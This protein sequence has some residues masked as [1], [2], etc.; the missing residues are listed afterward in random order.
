M[1]RGP[2]WILLWRSRDTTLDAYVDVHKLASGP[3]CMQA[4]PL[5]GRHLY[6]PSEA[7]VSGEKDM[8][9]PHLHDMVYQGVDGICVEWWLANV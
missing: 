2:C 9:A 5:Q 1:G 4:E 6:V 8:R 7:Q 3:G